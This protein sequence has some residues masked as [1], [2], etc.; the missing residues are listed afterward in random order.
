M[1]TIISS[2][3]ELWRATEEHHLTQLR[4]C[5][6]QQEAYHAQLARCAGDV[7]NS[8][9]AYQTAFLCIKKASAEPVQEFLDV[10]GG[11]SSVGR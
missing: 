3:I 4:R 9:L 5:P 8:M 2:N 6:P 7:V 11:L 1:S 10:S